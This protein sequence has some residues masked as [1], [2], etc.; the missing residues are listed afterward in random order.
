VFLATLISQNV[1]G[2]K[3]ECPLDGD[4][5]SKRRGKKKDSQRESTPE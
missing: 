5:M 1:F 4:A 3:I 2:D